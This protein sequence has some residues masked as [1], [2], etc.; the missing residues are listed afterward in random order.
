MGAAPL[1][2]KNARGYPR[3]M[4]APR[5][6]TGSQRKGLRKASVPGRSGMRFS[7][8]LSKNQDSLDSR[9]HRGRCGS[10]PNHAGDLA[11]NRARTVV[12]TE[13]GVPRGG[14]CGAMARRKDE[15]RDL[16]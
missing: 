2:G 8:N 4:R 7:A 12:V 1:P 6:S 16:V 10:L 14:D 15:P 11:I 9:V 3:S 13:L 5:S